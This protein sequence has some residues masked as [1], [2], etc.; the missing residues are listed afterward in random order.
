[1]ARALAEFGVAGVR[2]TIPFHAAVMGHADFVAGRLS[3]AFAEQ[4]LRT[5]LRR[6]EPA[7]RRVA[8]A[9]AAIRAYREAARPALSTP[10]ASGSPWALAARPGGRPAG[11]R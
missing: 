10:A 3:T 9:A 4:V 7:R 6:K 8:M 11:W 1:M 5:G 2:T